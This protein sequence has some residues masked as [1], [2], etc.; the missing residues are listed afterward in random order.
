MGNVTVV[1]LGRAPN[2]REVYGDEDVLVQPRRFGGLS[3]SAQEALAL[4]MPLVCL[5]WDPYS[6]VAAGVVPTLPDPVHVTMAGGYLPVEDADPA[7]VARLMD[8]LAENP[9]AVVAANEIA[10][11]WTEAHSWD[12]LRETWLEVLSCDS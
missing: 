12:A 4:G 10:R 11:K 3:L 5:G 7:Q 6:S 8:V 2:A 9:D 1:H